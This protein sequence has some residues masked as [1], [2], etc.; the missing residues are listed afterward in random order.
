MG[1]TNMRQ[2]HIGREGR[3][4]GPFAAEQIP[5]MLAEGQIQPDDLCWTEGMAEWQPVS[6]VF[7][8]SP[9]APPSRPRV[10]ETPPA[11]PAPQTNGALWNPALAIWWS[12]FLTPAFGAFLHA[13]NWKALGVPAKA[14]TSM[15]WFVVFM[16]GA[17]LCNFFNLYANEDSVLVVLS[18][19]WLLFFVWLFVFALPQVRYVKKNLGENYPR[20]PWLAPVLIAFVAAIAIGV[21]A[22]LT[23]VLL[24]SL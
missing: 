13:R 18:F 7:R 22:G 14:K 24:R 6:T 11:P 1:E 17:F 16:V 10:T 23:G 21:A 5:A 12:L 20:R 4:Y 9:G 8:T 3:Q 19:V 15:V 2:Y